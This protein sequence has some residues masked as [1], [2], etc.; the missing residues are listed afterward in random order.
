MRERDHHLISTHARDSHNASARSA[1]SNGTH[2]SIEDG[3]EREVLLR[4]KRY[5]SDVGILHACAK[6]R[7]LKYLNLKLTIGKMGVLGQ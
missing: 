1:S 7:G 3:K 5:V 4:V 2:V 6:R